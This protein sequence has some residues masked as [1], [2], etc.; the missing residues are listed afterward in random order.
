[1]I[2][3]SATAGIEVG[4]VVELLCLTGGVDVIRCR[5]PPRGPKVIVRTGLSK[6]QPVPGEIFTIEIERTWVFG[7]TRYAKGLITGSRLDVPRLDLEPLDLQTWDLWDPVEEAWLFEEQSHPIY[8]E[9]RAAG[10]RPRCEMEQVLPE[11]AVK[12]RWEEDPIVEAAELAACGEVGE[13]Q[14]LLEDLLTADLRCLDAH[15]HL[16]NVELRSRWPWA[17]DRA[18]RHYRAG[19]EI[20]NLTLGESFRGL[21]PWGM[22]DNRPYLRCLH[23]YGLYLWRSG[24]LAAAGEVFRRMLWLNPSDNQGARFNLAA[25]ES[26]RLNQD[27]RASRTAS[28]FFAAILRSAR[29]GPSGCRRPCSQF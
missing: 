28:G 25:V 24:D 16:G 29:A 23:G 12:L 17:L 4:H 6:A 26:T 1:M 3:T 13:A 21:L 27:P 19:L 5:V 11:E 20:A 15:A 22:L 10:P 8:E 2:D 7:H 18:G 14:D 9:I